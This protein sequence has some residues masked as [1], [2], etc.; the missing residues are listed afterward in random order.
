MSKLF[1]ALRFSY[2]Y[3]EGLIWKSVKSITELNYIYRRYTQNKEVKNGEIVLFNEFKS[4]YV[5]LSSF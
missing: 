4:F 2:V 3:L 5:A 1:V